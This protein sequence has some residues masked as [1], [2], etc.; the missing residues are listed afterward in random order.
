MYQG[1]ISARY[2]GTAAELGRVHFGLPD[3]LF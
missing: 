1:D 2:L 3:A